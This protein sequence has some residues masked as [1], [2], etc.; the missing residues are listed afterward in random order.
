MKTLAAI[1]TQ[2]GKPLELD[3]IAIP[4]LRSGQV[5]VKIA[6][7]GI[8]GT[9]LNEVDGKK[10]EDKWLPHCIGHEAIGAVVD[11]GPN[12]TRF[13]KD[14]KVILS[15]LKA[16]GLEAGGTNYKWGSRI[17]NAGPVTTFQNYAVVSENRLTKMV[18]NSLGKMQVLLGCAA[19]TGMGAVRNVL[20]PQEGE[21]IVIFGAGGVGLCALMMAKHM[22]LSPVIV[23]DIS[24]QRL[25]LAKKFG[26]D[27]I[28]NVAEKSLENVMQENDLQ[29]VDHLVEVTGNIAV[30]NKIMSYIRPQGGRAVI[31]GNASAGEVMKVSPSQFN[32]GKSILGT[33]GGDSKPERDFEV[34][35]H[36][37]DENDYLLGK[38]IESPFSLERVND[39]LQ[40]LRN[41]TV[42]RPILM[43]Q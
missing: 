25:A 6:Y 43:M 27:V 1:L 26:A 9:Q 21:S 19:P 2:T 24:D 16:D 5:L 3:E 30:F 38:M 41:R 15:W 28:V 17:V 7:S 20:R 11:I 12:V 40:C 10:G 31:V 13:V 33:W 22:K 14:D 37:L 8:C 35:C 23:A 34:F 39:A 18:S 42:A 36:I 4:K 32:M 29:H